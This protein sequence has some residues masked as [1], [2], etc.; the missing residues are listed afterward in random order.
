MPIETV[1]DLFRTLRATVT[2]YAGAVPITKKPYRGTAFFP[3]GFGVWRY[4]PSVDAPVFPKGGNDFVGHNF[5]GTDSQDER[6]VEDID[7]LDT[8]TWKGLIKHL[9]NPNLQ[10]RRNQCFFTNALMGLRPGRSVGTIRGNDAYYSQ[11]ER[12]LEIQITATRPRL[13][14]VLGI[15]TIDRFR[16]IS[17]QLRAAWR[18]EDTLESIAG[19]GVSV[20]EAEFGGHRCIAQSC[21]T[22]VPARSAKQ[23]IG[24]TR[25]RSGREFW[26]RG[27]SDRANMLASSRLCV[28]VIWLADAVRPNRNVGSTNPQ[29]LE[30]QSPSSTQ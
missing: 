16:A 3:G 18:T 8:Q 1:E 10:L 26:A 25:L 19:R 2:T 11:C 14:V 21:R 24:K 15:E 12:F 20:L 9:D 30:I 28:W 13:V 29:L 23:R 22:P 27:W 17:P 5:D 7:E 6:D 4:D